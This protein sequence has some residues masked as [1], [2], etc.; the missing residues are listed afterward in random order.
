MLLSAAMAQPVI[1]AANRLKAGD[2]YK[3]QYAQAAN[4]AIGDTGANRVWDY[5]ALVAG[6]N[7]TADSMALPGSFQVPAVFGSP[8]LMGYFRTNNG[9]VTDSSYN[10]YVVSGDTLRTMG[11]YSIENNTTARLQHPMIIFPY[12]PYTY[13]YSCADS[14][15]LYYNSNN[16][17]LDTAIQKN[18]YKVTGYGTLTLPGNRT[19]NNVLQIVRKSQLFFG[20]SV[21]QNEYVMYMTPGNPWPLMEVLMFQNTIES[22]QYMTSYYS[23]P[24]GPTY[25]FTGSGNWNNPANWQGG[26]MPPTS[27]PPGSVIIISHAP[28]GSCIINIPVT[29]PPGVQFIVA[30]GANL[31]LPGNLT[32]Q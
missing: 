15:Q 21:I 11:Y 23:A 18:S 19:F 9:T 7:V 30:T 12:F 22:V 3:T 17:F 24:I 8:N 1:T 20:T 27:L 29:I 32:I 28:G 2:W 31:V 5:S 16:T 14:S 10:F 26:T 13:G 25:T 6:G 4:V